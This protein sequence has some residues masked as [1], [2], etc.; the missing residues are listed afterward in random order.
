M[1][2]LPSESPILDEVLQAVRKSKYAVVKHEDKTAE[3]DLILKSP[4]GRTVLVEIKDKISALDSVDVAEVYRMKKKTGADEALLLSNT[5]VSTSG[6]ASSEKADIRIMDTKK[7]K[8]Y[9]QS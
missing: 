8:E 4:D 1:K 6:S 2:G 9:L 7:F 3:P 5:T